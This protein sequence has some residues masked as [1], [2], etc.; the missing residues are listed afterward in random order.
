MGP[1]RSTSGIFFCRVCVRSTASASGSRVIG[2]GDWIDWLIYLF[3]FNLLI[4]MPRRHPRGASSAAR[5]VESQSLASRRDSLFPLRRSPLSIRPLLI[6]WLFRR[7]PRRL[8]SLG[9][10]LTFLRKFLFL[11][12]VSCLSASRLQVQDTQIDSCSFKNNPLIH[13]YQVN[14][15][16]RRLD[17]L[18]PWP[19]SRKVKRFGVTTRLWLANRVG[20]R[21]WP[22]T[23]RVEHKCS[24]K[25]QNR[26]AQPTSFCSL[27]HAAYPRKHP[28]TVAPR[29][30]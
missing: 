23:G 1:P 24:V 4:D 26:K 14:R 7:F 25:A 10:P 18:L 16:L 17:F 11:A 2:F 30:L 9:R 12:Q 29:L 28:P 19:S 21:S 6:F 5:W 13:F 20:E 8:A 22:F 3:S 15:H 27:M